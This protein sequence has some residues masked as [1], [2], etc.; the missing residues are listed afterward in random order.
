MSKVLARYAAAHPDRVAS[1]DHGADGYTVR[2]AKGWVWPAGS[3]SPALY[4]T[5]KATLTGLR[6]AVQVVQDSRP[7]EST[8]TTKP[9]GRPAAG[10][11]GAHVSGYPRVRLE[12]DVFKVL[13][14]VAHELGVGT[15]RAASDLLRTALKDRAAVLHAGH[16]A[17]ELVCLAACVGAP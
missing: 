12:P 8:T 17:S 5:V 16:T 4:R 11:D 2:L 13:T 10:R 1:I 9:V 3:S 6:Q 14:R 15:C 7:V